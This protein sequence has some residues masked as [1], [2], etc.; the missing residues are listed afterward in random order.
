MVEVVAKM[1]AHTPVVLV[2]SV[3]NVFNI[4]TH[5]AATDSIETKWVA[6]MSAGV[7]VA[8]CLMAVV[9]VVAL[10]KRESQL[11]LEFVRAVPV[12]CEMTSLAALF[13]VLVVL[14]EDQ[15]VPHVEVRSVA[16]K[17]RSHNTIE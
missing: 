10:V 17:L 15:M 5:A 4:R 6:T 13:E 1:K 14:A 12:L 3:G 11:V 7:A 8:V 16:T 2:L 9:M